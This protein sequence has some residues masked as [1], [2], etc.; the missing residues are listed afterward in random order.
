MFSPAAHCKYDATHWS[1]MLKQHMSLARAVAVERGEAR[2]D[3]L[4]GQAARVAVTLSGE[5]AGS[6]CATAWLQI[7]AHLGGQT[8]EGQHVDSVTLVVEGPDP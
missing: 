8:G 2:R 7:G 5:A 6:V 4:G 1:G 3:V